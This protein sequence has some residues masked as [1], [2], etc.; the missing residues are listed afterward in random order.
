MVYSLDDDSALKVV[1][2]HIEIVSEGEFL[3][4]KK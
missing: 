3:E 1:D 4:L 2:D